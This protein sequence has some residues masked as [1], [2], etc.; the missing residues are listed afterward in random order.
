MLCMASAVLMLPTAGPS[1]AQGAV[2]RAELRED[3][4]RF[5]GRYIDQIGR[6]EPLQD[7]SLVEIDNENDSTHDGR[8]TWI[9]AGPSTGIESLEVWGLEAYGA[10]HVLQE[11][12]T[13]K[14]DDVEG[15]SKIYEAIVKGEVPEDPGLPE[16]FNVLVKEVR[17]L[18]LNMELLDAEVEE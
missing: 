7:P 9:A 6:Y 17:G 8:V 10:A 1:S 15:R 13:V 14:S 5:T 11:L 18:G 12:L 3:L 4:F 2:S 16:S